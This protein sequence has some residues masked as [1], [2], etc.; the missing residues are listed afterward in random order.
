MQKNGANGGA[1]NLNI[2]TTNAANVKLINNTIAYNTTQV[3]TTESRPGLYVAGLED[4]VV[5][6]NNIISSNTDA[7][8]VP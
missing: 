8:A 5:L 1:I 3:A 2:L 6:I 7:Q 4:K